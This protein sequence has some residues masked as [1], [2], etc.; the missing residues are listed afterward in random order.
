MKCL[1]LDE[2]QKLCNDNDNDPS[3]DEPKKVTKRFL[4]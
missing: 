4:L 2:K 3:I 1:F